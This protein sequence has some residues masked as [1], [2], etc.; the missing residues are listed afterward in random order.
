MPRPLLRMTRIRQRA[1]GMGKFAGILRR[2]IAR[3]AAEEKKLLPSV[4]RRAAL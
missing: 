3:R 2:I 4:T 1:K